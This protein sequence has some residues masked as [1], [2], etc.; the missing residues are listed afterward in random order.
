MWFASM[1]KM[2]DKLSRKRKVLTEDEEKPFL[3]HLEDL[4]KMIM[5][6]ALT[7]VV[8]VIGCFAFNSWFFKVVRYPMQSAGLASAMEKNLPEGLDMAKWMSIH[9]AARGAS[10]LE[11]DLRRHFLEQALPD[12]ALRPYAEAFLIYHATSLLPLEAQEGFLETAVKSL[13]AE[14]S[15]GVMEA[16]QAM[17]RVLPSPSLEEMRPVIEN[18][19]MAPPETFMLSMKLSTFAGIIIS[20]PLLFYFLLEFILPGLNHR[21]RRLMWPALSIGFGLFLTGVMFAYFGVIPGALQFFH[22]YS[23]DLG[24]KDMWKIGDYISFVT[25]F[26]LIFGVSFELPVVVMILVKLDLLSSATMRRTRAWAVIIIVVAGAILTPTQDILTLSMLSGPMIVMY[27]A[28]IWL[29]VLHERRRN[30]EEAEEENRDMARRAALVGVASVSAAKPGSVMASAEDIYSNPALDY[31]T[32]PAHGGDAGHGHE[33]D[34][35]QDHGDHSDGW[36]H[37]SHSGNDSYGADSGS[38]SGTA[39]GWENHPHHPDPEKPTAEEEQAQYMREHAHLFQN[40]DT[41]PESIP[42]EERHSGTAAEA[43]APEKPEEKEE[44]KSGD[45]PAPPATDSESKE[46]E[47]KKEKGTH[48]ENPPTL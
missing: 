4:R 33:L 13:P 7:L 48:G 32:D 43:P 23:A 11:G 18:V 6:I 30:R 29:A 17:R 46:E 3:E 41:H 5:R 1:L 8:A 37:D 42:V 9:N 16:A 27:E 40:Q 14:R 38:A 20:F 22:E 47:E 21:E 15:A 45:G 26:S 2:R 12:A 10:I 44:E 35:R 34:G 19:A 39:S 36:A 25:T 24:V 28:C 31:H